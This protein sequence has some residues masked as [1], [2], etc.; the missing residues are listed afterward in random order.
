MHTDGISKLAVPAAA[1]AHLLCQ[2]QDRS[3]I[4]KPGTEPQEEPASDT[5][6]PA[7]RDPFTAAGP[8]GAS[9]TVCRLHFR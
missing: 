1:R 8:V 6:A 7:L 9:G 5:S 2:T 3:A 4:S